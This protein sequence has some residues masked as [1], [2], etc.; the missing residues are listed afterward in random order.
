MRVPE[1][2]CWNCRKK[3][4]KCDLRK[5]KCTKCESRSTVCD[6][7]Q[8]QL[9][10]VGGAAVRGRL[11]SIGHGPHNENTS[12]ENATDTGLPVPEYSLQLSPSPVSPSP[13]LPETLVM[14]FR[15]AVWP[16]LQLSDQ[17]ISLDEN[18]L[19]HEPALREAV[20][21]VSQAHHHQLLGS[22]ASCTIS[23]GS[24]SREQSRQLALSRFRRRIEDGVG[25]EDDA[26]RLFQIVCIFCILDG[27]VFPDEQGNASEQHLRGGHSMLSAWESIPLKM[28]LAGGLQAHLFSVFATVDLVHSLL[29]GD[30][31]HFQPSTWSMFADVQAWWGRLSCEDP[32]LTIL[33]LYSEV[34]FLGN[35]VH[36][37]LPGTNG[38]VLAKRCLPPIMR[39]LNAHTGSRGRLIAPEFTT[40]DEWDAFCSIYEASASIYVYRALDS[41]CVDDEDV[42]HIVHRAVSILLDRPPS[43]MMAHCLIFPLLVVGSHCLHTRDRRA[44]S[45]VLSSSMSYLA[46]GNLV[47]MTNLLKDIWSQDHTDSNWWEM[48]RSVSKTVF[49]F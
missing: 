22:E 38:S 7:S 23:A 2:A 36:S 31:P 10:W 28:L 9:Q 30:K 19:M 13:L 8:R 5:P 34:A 40:L 24:Q 15:N 48:F 25:S 45:N 47:L 11:T 46:F 49:L 27:V 35:I 41:R 17:L 4:L 1:G 3:R 42:Q 20:L 33:K 44:V 29:S 21:A 37:H 16:R 6:Y 26:G 12:T 32:F 39:S 43:G 18:V 14:Y